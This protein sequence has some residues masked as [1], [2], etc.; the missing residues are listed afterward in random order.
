MDYLKRGMSIVPVLL[1]DKHPCVRWKPF[2]QQR[3][4]P[5]DVR[6]WARRWP[7]TGWSVIL[8][9]V[10][11]LFAVDVDGEEAHEVLLERL[12]SEPMTPKVYSGS[13][14]PYR[15]HLYFRYP[16]GVETK[17]KFT[18]WNQKLE[19]RGNRGI[20]VLP[21]S[22]HKSGNRYT[23]A[24]GRSFEDVPLCDVPAPI[25]DA[26]KN[27]NVPGSKKTPLVSERTAAT[28]T[29]AA[30]NA[31]ER[32]R[33]YLRKFPAAVEGDG[34]DKTTFTAACRLV[35]DFNL[36]PEAALPLLLEYNQRCLPPW[37]EEELIRKLAAA[38]SLPNPRGRLLTAKPA[39]SSLPSSGQT[40]TPIPATSPLALARIRDVGMIDRVMARLFELLGNG[41]GL[42]SDASG[43]PHLNVP[44]PSPS[45]TAVQFAESCRQALGGRRALWTDEQGRPWALRCATFGGEQ[46][47]SASAELGN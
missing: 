21:P 8:G 14:D 2:Q 27:G 42:F 43:F 24:T 7:D 35:I 33:I 32:A 1:G 26:L 19:F 41:R 16:D 29:L 36:T 18:P 4:R 12:G 47:C 22:I 17:A 44:A 9:P 40:P 37:S 34:G 39:T 5:E 25:L 46:S 20:T 15:Y 13:E 30:G 11:G 28:P 10:S 31:I 45:I 38:D 6:E 23:F 3:P